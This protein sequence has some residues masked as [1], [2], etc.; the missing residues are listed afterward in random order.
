MCPGLAVSTNSWETQEG[1][2]TC[3]PN[4]FISFPGSLTGAL[5]TLINTTPIEETLFA[6]AVRGSCRISV[7]GLWHSIPLV[8]LGKQKSC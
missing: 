5:Q 8:P 7:S 6:E 1:A 3:L 2:E 4:Q